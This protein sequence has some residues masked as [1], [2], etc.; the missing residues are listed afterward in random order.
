MSADIE[1]G[2]EA[3]R[4]VFE[5]YAQITKRVVDSNPR[6]SDTLASIN[7]YLDEALRHWT[8]EHDRPSRWELG[9]FERQPEADPRRLA[10]LRRMVA[11]NETKA[12]IKS[13]LVA[14]RSVQ[15]FG[16]L[17][18]IQRC[19]RETGNPDFVEAWNAFIG[20][21]SRR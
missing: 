3:V 18:W 13:E 20:Y 14:W 1:Y 2:A 4:E 5:A 8:P 6:D 12:R 15:R 7:G 17:W 19:L 21:F 10:E 16:L 9:H 11:A